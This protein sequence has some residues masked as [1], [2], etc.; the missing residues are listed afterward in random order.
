MRRFLDRLYALFGAIAAL[1]VLAILVL[2][3]AGSL[4]REFGLRL[5]FINDVVAWCCA[6]ASFFGM[7]YAFKRGDFVRVTLLLDRAPPRWR[8]RLELLALAIA[9]LAV[10][11]LAVWACRFTYD[12]YRFNEIAG[13]MVAIPI[14]IPQS[15]FVLGSLLFFVAV[16]DELVTVA[17]GGKPAYVAAVEARHARGDFSSDI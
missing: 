6:A 1:F 15:S 13:G 4:G 7:A 12:S 3:I 8:R 16:L 9:A 5:G 14:W 11:Y 10:G 2:M 17:R